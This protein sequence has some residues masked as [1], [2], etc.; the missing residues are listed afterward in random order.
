MWI[1][2]ELLQPGICCDLSLGNF[3][4]LALLLSGGLFREVE[5]IA[6]RGSENNASFTEKFYFR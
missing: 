1:W 2:S 5:R 3:T 6:H 4:T